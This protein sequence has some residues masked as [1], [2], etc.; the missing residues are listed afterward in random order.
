MQEIVQTIIKDKKYN[1]LDGGILKDNL[2][3]LIMELEVS[4]IFQLEDGM[5]IGIYPGDIFITE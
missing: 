4:F 5:Y 2:Y 1:L 3:E